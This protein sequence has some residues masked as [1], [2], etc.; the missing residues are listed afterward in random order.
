VLKQ[1][2]V[3]AVVAGAGAI[4]LLVAAPASAAPVGATT[5]GVETARQA[6][7]HPDLLCSTKFVADGVRIHLRASLSST[8]LGLG[9]RGQWF[10]I[11]Y[12]TNVGGTWWAY[13]KDRSTGVTGFVYDSSAYLDINLCP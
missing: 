10:D 1:W 9:Y 11:Q 4:G 13:G 8:V 12:I 3:A 7:V 6:A 2:M 5:V